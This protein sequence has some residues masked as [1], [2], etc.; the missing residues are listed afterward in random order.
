MEAIRSRFTNTILTPELVPLW[1]IF[2]VGVRDDSSTSAATENHHSTHLVSRQL[3]LMM[4]DIRV[5]SLDYLVA[6]LAV[7][8][9]VQY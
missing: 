6:S 5:I 8:D 3:L 1:A 7:V 9:G 4:V 2:R